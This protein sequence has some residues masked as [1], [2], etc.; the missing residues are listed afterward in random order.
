MAR[1]LKDKHPIDTD[2]QTDTLTNS[3]KDRHTNTPTHIH[4]QTHT[5][6]SNTSDGSHFT[7]RHIQGFNLFYE[8]PAKSGVLRE[9]L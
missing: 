1:S 3:V 8:K 4:I 2:R 5:Q 7:D 9:N 6:T